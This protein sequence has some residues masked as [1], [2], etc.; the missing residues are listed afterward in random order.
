M[1]AGAATPAEVAALQAA[2]C[3]TEYLNV[4][5]R[6]YS[7]A[8]QAAALSGDFDVLL[9][10]RAQIAVPVDWEMDP[11]DSRSWRHWLHTLGW[12]MDALL[13]V[14]R[15]GGPDSQD[16]LVQARDLVLDWIAA[17]PPGPS[18][19][20]RPSWADKVT[21][22]RAP[23]VA[24]VARAAACEGLLTDAQAGILVDSLR[25]HGAYLVRYHAANDHGLYGDYGLALIAGYLP[26]LAEAEDWRRLALRRFGPS[27]RKRFDAGE[28]IWLVN[29]PAYQATVAN[30]MFL[31]LD[32]VVA[33]AGLE[34]LARRMRRGVGWFIRP[35]GE[36]SAFGDHH[37]MVPLPDWVERVGEAVSGRRLLPRSGW[38]FVKRRSS[39]LAASASFF[40]ATHK[41]ADD[42]S[43]ELFDR[44]RPIVTDTGHY[45]YEYDRRWY[46]FQ[47]AAR[48]HSGVTVDG[49]TFN[50]DPRHAYGSGM[51]A[52]GRGGGWEA[53]LGVNP[54]LRLQGVR[55]RRLYLYR[56]GVA[57]ILVDSLRSPR[58]HV[59]RRHF[60][61]A[62]RIQVARRPSGLVLRSDGFRGSLRS[63]GTPAAVEL[64]RGETAG[65]L[66]G[67][68]FPDYRE[69]VPRWSVVLRSGSR[70]ADL[71]TVLALA[72]RRSAR[73][74]EARVS[75]TATR[76]RIALPGAGPRLV[77][78]VRRGRALQ[79]RSGKV[80]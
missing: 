21:A 40:F 79:V 68:S 35:D 3:P 53:I 19:A 67:W 9:G 34:R 45:D 10:R 41:Q 69:L 44:G 60:Q 73:A 29:S 7:D 8:E 12:W 17:N 20:F 74:G 6:A 26:F 55:H 13:Y 16:A 23:Y 33:D 66:A 50:L 5:Q 63:V 76:I 48:A 71:V 47:R 77:E 42:L 46:R 30:L 43:F 22:D 28:R 18:D 56:P 52:A 14:Y 72:G 39:Y 80:P 70:N 62:P 24:Y 25:A 15:Q 38:A 65:R 78:I 58:R 4:F 54:L 11:Y 75:G 31:W 64:D 37:T 32:D 57:L 51:L 27:L 59:Y 1:R 61:L 36:M 49:E 2:P